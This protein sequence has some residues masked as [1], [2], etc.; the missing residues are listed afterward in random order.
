M[1]EK[2]A[3]RKL[4]AILSADVKGYSR[5]MGEDELST[6]ETLKQYREIF[7]NLV[8][9]YQGRVIDSPGDNVVIVGAGTIGLS[10]LQAAR[11]SGAR[12]IMVA[13]MAEARKEYAKKLGATM[14]FDPTEVN[15]PEEVLKAT[16][17]VGADLGFECVGNPKTATLV[18][19]SVRR[20]GRMVV[21]GVFEK[22][23]EINLNFCVFFEKEI[24]GSLGYNDEFA[25]VLSYLVDGRLQADPMITGKISLNDLLDKG[26]T[27]LIKNKD[28]NI[29]ILVSPQ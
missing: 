17:G 4:T 24:I 3:K 29:K 6:V 14:V 21:L 27:E 8:T 10:T 22:P 28:R 13:E 1:S 5:L 16:D 18:L 26:F 11:A 23:A 20:G 15:V 7:G 12:K 25:T 19:D 9:D 2:R